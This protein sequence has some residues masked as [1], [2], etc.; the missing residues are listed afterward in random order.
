M[1]DIYLNFDGVLHPDHLLYEQGCAPTLL[2]SEHSALEY[3][4]FL[5]DAL[6][7]HVDAAIVLNTW[8]TFYIG[9]DDCLEL[10]PPTLA[11]RVIGSTVQHASSYDQIPVRY[12]EVE[13]YIASRRHQAFLIV[14]HANARYSRDL[15]PYL[16]LLDPSEGLSNPT[17]CRS[18]KRRIELLEKI[19]HRAL[20]FS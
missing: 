19:R 16:L 2:T 18:L 15:N 5:A 11:A 20:L 8:W 10:L 7:S 3:T 1:M 4:G 12:R 17:A 6:E 14:D 13:R 9:F